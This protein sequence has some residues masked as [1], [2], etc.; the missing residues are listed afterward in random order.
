[1]YVGTKRPGSV[2]PKKIEDGSISSGHIGLGR[3]SSSGESSSRI[4]FAPRS[5]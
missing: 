3:G 4:A 1:M 5:W 2:P